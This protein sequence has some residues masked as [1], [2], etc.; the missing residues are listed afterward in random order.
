[1]STVDTLYVAWRSPETRAIYPVGRLTLTPAAPQY[2]FVYI[3]GA[4]SAQAH[5]FTPFAGLPELEQT[6]LS[7]ELF[8]LF[9]NRVMSGTR[10]DYRDYVARLGLDPGHAAALDILA[11]SAG[12]RP[13]DKLEFFAP[14]QRTAETGKLVWH[15]LARGIRYM[16]MA[17]ERVSRLQPGDR[18]RWMLDRQNEFDPLAVAL[19]T[20]DRYLIGYVPFYFVGDMASLVQEGK[21]LV[22]RVEKVNLR[23]APIHHR[24]LCRLEGKWADEF[25]PFS[26]RQYRPLGVDASGT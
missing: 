4:R 23:P 2:E 22:I 15:F 17:E 14:P 26:S 3:E 5:G 6:Y 24:V 16:P 19:R 20:E 25:M 13:E 9:A 11:R 10:P 12:L 1:M 21:D 7:D 8:P 18:L